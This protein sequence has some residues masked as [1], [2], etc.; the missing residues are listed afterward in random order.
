[1]S[2]LNQMLN[3]LEKRGANGPLAD[4]PTRAVHAQSNFKIWLY[5]A[6]GVA[7]LG[8]LAAAGWA[9]Y[10]PA[11]VPPPVVSAAPVPAVDVVLPVSQVVAASQAEGVSQVADAAPP[12]TQEF[13]IAPRLSI[14][15]SSIPL[16]RSLREKPLVELAVPIRDAAPR[17]TN[18]TGSVTKQLKV[19]SPQQ[20][21][22]NEFRKA[23]L[24]AQQG[25]FKEAAAGYEEALNLDAAHDMAR[26][27]LV[28]VLLESRLN[29]D[30]EKTL[31]NGLALNLKQ[32]HFAMLLARLQVERNALPLALSTLEK[33][34]PYADQL[35][36]YQAFVAALLQRQNRHKEAITHYQIALQLSP[37]SGLWL[38]GLGISLQAVQR[39][40]D[41]LDAYQRALDS[42]SLSPELQ[43][44]VVQRMQEIR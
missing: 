35:A 9:L 1:M 11:E 30:A 18:A 4:M 41:A 43:A 26:E 38:M 34:L 32:T 20:Q 37:N 40:E 25:R 33:A 16:P 15:L 31:Q 12:E 39:K 14:E 13:A 17:N 6:G 3:D 36:D 44:Y 8:V 42:R 2:L 23:N 10:K 29:A 19:V 21:A 7:L 22:E 27:A 28:A 24:L 5:A